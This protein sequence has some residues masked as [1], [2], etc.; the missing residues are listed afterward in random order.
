[1][2]VVSDASPLLSLAIIDRLDL[3][4]NMYGQILIA[5]AVHDEI[6][7]SGDQRHGLQ[8]NTLNWLETRST[9]NPIV[10]ALLLRELDRGE[11][12][13]IALAV[14]MKADLLLLDERKAR[15]IAAY[16][17]LPMAGLLDIL[18][19]A[20]RVHLIHSIKPVL[21]DLIAHAK[22][23]VSP[24]LYQRVLINAGELQDARST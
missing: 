5:P 1:M 10:L 11:A 16:L 20:K 22:F 2:I 23:R 4:E 12:E 19:E 3:L 6:L 7:G 14:E 8:I 13:A 24:K 18:A 15:S 9:I 21:D 17:D